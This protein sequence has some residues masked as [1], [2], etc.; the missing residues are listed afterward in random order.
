MLCQFLFYHWSWKSLSFLDLY[1]W[2]WWEGSIM[3]GWIL[4]KSWCS[5]SSTRH[6]FFSSLSASINHTRYRKIFGSN[7]LN[8][9]SVPTF[10]KETSLHPTTGDVRQCWCLDMLLFDPLAALCVSRPCL[11]LTGFLQSSYFWQ[12]LCV[13]WNLWILSVS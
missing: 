10:S 1:K 3:A 13:F 4:Q 11:F 2:W 5:C 6:C 9:V 7:L 12:A 8:T